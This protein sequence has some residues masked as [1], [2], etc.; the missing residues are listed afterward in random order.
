MPRRCPKCNTDNPDT[1]QYC[2]DCGTQLPSLEKIE[3]TET[4]E[5]PKEELT[6]GVTFAGRYQI[7]EELGKGGMGKVYKVHDTKIKEKIALKLIKPEIAKDKKTIERFSNEL[8]FARKIRHKNICQMFD[9]GE[10]QGTHFITMEFVEGQDLKKLIRQSGQLA[11]GTTLSIT[12]W[13]GRGSYIR[14]YPQRSK[15]QQYYDRC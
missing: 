13:T 2:G 4:L 3:V 7:I 15:T 1:K 9:L 6:T 11:I 12:K 5:T 14:S 8:K 10:D